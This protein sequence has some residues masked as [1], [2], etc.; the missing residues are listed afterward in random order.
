MT[1]QQFLDKSF[2]DQ[3]TELYSDD[4]DAIADKILAE[5]DRDYDVE[6]SVKLAKLFKYV[7]R[8]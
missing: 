7:L 6:V 1:R 8:V 2:H 5:F 4:D 3:S